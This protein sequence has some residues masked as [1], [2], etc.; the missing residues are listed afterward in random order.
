MRQWWSREG[1]G[2]GEG[3]GREDLPIVKND[4]YRREGELTFYLFKQDDF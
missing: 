2:Q 3:R 1:G 4:S